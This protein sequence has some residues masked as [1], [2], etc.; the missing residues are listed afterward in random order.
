MNV[1]EYGERP[2]FNWYVSARELPTESLF[3]IQTSVS[4]VFWGGNRRR[5]N[6]YYKDGHW[7]SVKVH[8][9]SIGLSDDEPTPITIEKAAEILLA[10]AIFCMGEHR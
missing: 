8:L 4:I 6:V 5:H 9:K 10:D 7:T 1:S 2:K 3:S